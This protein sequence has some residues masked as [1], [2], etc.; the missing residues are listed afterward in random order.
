MLPLFV[1]NLAQYIILINMKISAF[2][3]KLPNGIIY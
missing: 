3:T 1:L 2:K